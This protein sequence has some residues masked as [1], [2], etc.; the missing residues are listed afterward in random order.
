MI[1]I[2]VMVQRSQKR[3]ERIHAVEKKP[4]PKHTTKKAAN[5]PKAKPPA[6]K[7]RQ[8]RALSTEQKDENKRKREEE[9][10]M[11]TEFRAF[12]AESQKKQ[13][14]MNQTMEQTNVQLTT[15]QQGNDQPDYIRNLT[16]T[17]AS[18]QTLIQSMNLEIF[19][20][21]S[22]YRSDLAEQ[23]LTHR[24][25]VEELNNTIECYRQKEDAMQLRINEWRSQRTRLLSELEELKSNGV[26]SV[27]SSPSTVEPTPKSTKLTKLI[28]PEPG[29][30]DDVH[31][32]ATHYTWL[33]VEE[34]NVRCMELYGFTATQLQDIC[35]EL[36]PPKRKKGRGQKTTAYGDKQ[37]FLM[38]L[39][40]FTHYPTIR[41]L[42]QKFGPSTSA[43][44]SQLT[45]LIL[46]V[47]TKLFQWSLP[48]EPIKSYVRGDYFIN[49][50]TPQDTNVADATY[51]F[52][53]NKHGIWIHCIHCPV[54]GKAVGYY[55]SGVRK[56]DKQWL[57]Q[58][59]PLVEKSD[60]PLSEVYENR[61]RGK[62]NLIN[63]QYRGTI[64]DI[65]NT[66]RVLLA[67][68]NVDLGYDN[69]LCKRVTVDLS[70]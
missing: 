48:I 3:L 11:L 55:T 2:Q 22:K 59:S 46:N 21:G 16:N 1:V 19:N 50:Q 35:D 8:S 20:M 25:E 24:K 53:Q 67:L 31:E 7:V 34:G 26:P 66:I 27:P 58:F 65:D 32:Q 40:H 41:V 30:P 56:I 70:A 51:C 63:S 57:Q 37:V 12:I 49:I 44:S 43:I 14:T 47:A 23:D 64:Q 33:A 54:T 60:K 13:K 36:C 61:M 62:F 15:L 69:P 10:T 18:Q 28:K 5:K 6:K 9:R 68:T 38:L 52:D 4:A 39:Y 42:H 17:V 45:R 29:A